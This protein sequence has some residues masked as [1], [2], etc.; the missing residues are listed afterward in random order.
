M[1]SKSL[2]SFG[3]SC[4]DKPY[5]LIVFDIRVPGTLE[6]LRSE[7]AAWREH[8]RVEPLGPDHAVLVVLAGGAATPSEGRRAA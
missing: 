4:G 3:R 1:G 7:Q 8:A 6:R 2:T 5:E